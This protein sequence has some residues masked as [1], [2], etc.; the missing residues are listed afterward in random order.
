MSHPRFNFFPRRLKN[1]ALTIFWTL[2]F[3]ALLWRAALWLW[4]L[5]QGG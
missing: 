4:G 2:F 3:L 1:A 5:L